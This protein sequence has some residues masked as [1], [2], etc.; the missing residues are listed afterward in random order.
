MSY[1]PVIGLEIHLQI[2]TRSKM[3]CSSPNSPDGDEPNTHI[4]EVCTG[5][6]GSLPVV[7]KEAL[8]RAILMG[9]SLNC[10]IAHSTKFDRK[11]Y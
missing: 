8:D 3:F 7:N 6:P 11:N 9:L 1:Q 2:K 10:E 4:C 5:Q